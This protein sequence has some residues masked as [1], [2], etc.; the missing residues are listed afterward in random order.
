MCLRIS[1]PTF[2]LTPW[3][4][5]DSTISPITR[6]LVVE[7]RH[8]HSTVTERHATEAADNN[9]EIPNWIPNQI[10]NGR[11]AI[12]DHPIRW[13]NLPLGTC[14]LAHGSGVGGVSAVGASSRPADINTH[15][16]ALTMLSP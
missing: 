7:S 6:L 11:T 2:T 5:I 4:E 10:R 13:G 3:L 12:T 8:C 15:T 16:I 9:T 1:K 14:G